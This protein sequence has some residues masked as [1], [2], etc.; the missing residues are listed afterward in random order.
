MFGSAFNSACKDGWN[1]GTKA[2]MDAL[3]EIGDTG[4]G[5]NWRHHTSTTRNDIL[6][7]LRSDEMVDIVTKGNLVEVMGCVFK[8]GH[9]LTLQVG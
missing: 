3:K 4:P 7:L 6:E 8:C 2:L 1:R 5:Y 9:G